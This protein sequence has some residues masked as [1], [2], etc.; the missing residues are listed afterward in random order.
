MPFLSVPRSAPTLGFPL[1][2]GESGAHL[3]L[4]GPGPQSSA[5]QC[6]GSAAAAGTFP[7]A[8]AS[9]FLLTDRFS[10]FPFYLSSPLPPGLPTL[11]SG[12]LAG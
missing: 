5:E 1:G 11:S 7:C 6:L 3:S 8:P 10:K 4:D 12:P 9:P 2:R